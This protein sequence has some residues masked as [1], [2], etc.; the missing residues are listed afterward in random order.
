MKTEGRSDTTD[1]GDTEE[2]G[3][4]SKRKGWRIGKNV[5]FWNCYFFVY[6]R[7]PIISSM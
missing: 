3:K 7:D 2:E 4:D 1:E 5:N 6:N